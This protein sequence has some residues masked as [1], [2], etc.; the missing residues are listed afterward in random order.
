MPDLLRYQARRLEELIAIARL[1]GH[2]QRDAVRSEH[3]PGRGAHIGRQPVRGLAN[4]F[5]IGLDEQRMIEP[6]VHVR[7]IDI[8]AGVV[9][10]PVARGDDVVA[11]L[12][13]ARVG[14]MSGS[15]ET[16]RVPRAV[17]VHLVQRVPDERVPVAH[18]HVD[19]QRMSRGR[20]PLAQP[21]RLPL[22]SGP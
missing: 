10:Q 3:E 2:R 15:D 18:P 6:A 1:L 9:T 14:V 22:A 8:A 20:Q 16:D 12:L 13:A 21:V 4:V 19:G 11:V 7:D 17:L 5:G